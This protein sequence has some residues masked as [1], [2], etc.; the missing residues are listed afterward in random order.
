MSTLEDDYLCV[1]VCTDDA[2]GY[3]LGCGRPP[4]SAL[5]AMSENA[6]VGKDEQT[7]VEAGAER[8]TG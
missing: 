2:D 8:Q 6:D 1:G 5:L 7:P 4:L 3:C